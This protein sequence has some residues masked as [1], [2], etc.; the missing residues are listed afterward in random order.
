MTVEIFDDRIC[1]LGEGPWYD[2]HTARVGWVDILGRSVL[3]RDLAGGGTGALAT[4]THVGA[5]VPRTGG[6][7]VLCLRDGPMLLE[8]DGTRQVLGSFAEADAAAGGPRQDGGPR[9]GDGG[10]PRLRAND[11]KADPY[12]RLWLGTTAYDETPGAGSLYRLDPGARVP[13]RVLGEV[14]ISN[15]LGWSPDGSRMYYVDTPTRRIDVF[16]YHGGTGALTGR[17]P[18]AVVEDGAGFPDGMCVDAA[19]GVW[20]ALWDGA[21]VRRYHPDGSLDRVVEVGTPRVT[22]CAFAGDGFGRLIITTARDPSGDGCGGV[23]YQH[24]PGDVAGAAVHRYRG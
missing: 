2:E 23:T 16:D 3:W 10:L 13:E 4:A 15:G 6:G 14:T 18:F 5:A 7:L 21:A 20:V 19:G 8:P 11:A 9:Q 22:S 1:Q 17:R 12:G 24:L